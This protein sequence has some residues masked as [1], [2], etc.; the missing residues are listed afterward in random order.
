MPALLD[1]IFRRKPRAKPAAPVVEPANQQAMT[2]RA[3][4][5][6]A[7]AGVWNANHWAAAD[8]YD[9][10]S[11]NSK[12]VRASLVTR[13]RLECQN[14]GYMDGAAT[15]HA[16]YLVRSGPTLQVLTANTGF[17]TAVET[18]WQQW[19]EAIMFR[20]KLH[21]MAEA[22]VRDGEPFAVIRD[23]PR[24]RHPITLDVVPFE[25]EQCQ[26][27]MLSWGE[28]GYIDGMKF[29][30]WGNPEW[31]DVLKQHPGGQWAYQANTDPERVP[32]EFMLHWF[33]M[34][35][36]G[37]HRGVPECSSTLNLGAGSRRHRESTNAAA[38]TAA[39]HSVIVETN[40]SPDIPSRPLVAPWSGLPMQKNQF[41]VLPWNYHA[42]QLRA[43]NP[44]ATYGEFH[45]HNVQE[46]GRPLSM[47]Y[48]VSACDH[49]QDS[50]ASGKLNHQ[51]WFMRLDDNRMDCNDTVLNK[52]FAQFSRMAVLT[53]GWNANPNAPP[54]RR[55]NWPRHPVAD[56]Q[57]EASANETRLKTGQVTLTRLYDEYGLD[58]KT[59]LPQMAE[60]YGL[61]VP[62]MQALLRVSIFNNGNVLAQPNKPI[63]GGV[64]A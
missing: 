6:A 5:D 18:V 34:R 16:D 35:R 58:Y 52:L 9:A 29:D 51:P 22:K 21:C 13:S 27:P 24:V 50:F 47:P 63:A 60:D 7:G 36:P 28:V 43:E 25:T 3:G 40:L 11:S 49:S 10:D 54:A 59:E 56:V 14:N 26:T 31:Y 37:Q 23:N 57:A 45:R 19:C 42:T 15:T 62:E 53:Y 32:A 38:E 64:A 17:N 12:S 2:V 46:Q 55:W 61:T 41:V 1:R 4:Y 33:R 48:S 8:S 39:N 44:N 30:Q 20:R